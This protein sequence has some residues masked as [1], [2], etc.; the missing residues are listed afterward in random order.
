MYQ[1]WLGG[2]GSAIG[3]VAAFAAG[4]AYRSSGSH[5]CPPIGSIG[6]PYGNGPYRKI[7]CAPNSKFVTMLADITEKL[8]DLP[9]RET[10]NGQVDWKLF[11]AARAAAKADA[12][13]GDFFAAVRH[14]SEAIRGIMRQLRDCRPTVSTVM[15]RL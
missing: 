4:L 9:D 1:H 10:G 8:R 5:V 13:R 11:D 7:Q 2:I 12:E 14:Y 6:G 3:F 15:D